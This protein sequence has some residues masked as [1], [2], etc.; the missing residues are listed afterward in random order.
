MLVI[1]SSIK[2]NSIVIVKVKFHKTCNI[3]T[4]DK[5]MGLVGMGFYTREHGCASNQ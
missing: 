5:E 2:G 3:L 1:L 4:S